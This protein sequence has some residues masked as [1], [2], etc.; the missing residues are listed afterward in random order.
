LT[1]NEFILIAPIIVVDL[2]DRNESMKTGPIEVRISIKMKTP[3][4]ENTQAYSPH[5]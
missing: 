3:S 4:H 2:S 5:T 1:P